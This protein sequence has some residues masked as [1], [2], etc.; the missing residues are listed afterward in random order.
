MNKNIVSRIRS[1]TPARLA[2]AAP[3][4]LLSVAFAPPLSAQTNYTWAGNGT[5]LWGNSNA[6][7][8]N[9]TNLTFNNRTDIIFDNDTV[10]TRGNAT[11]INGARTIR[12][13][14]IGANYVGS[15][16]ATFDIRTYLNF[17]D[18]AANLTFAA[19]SGNASITVAQSTSG[20]VQV[21]LGAASSSTQNQ[22]SIVLSTN[23]DLAQNNTH[24]G[25]TG[26]QFDGKITGAGAIN[27]TG[28][29]E[30][31]LA[32]DNSGWSGG[33]NINEGNVTIFA[34]ANAMGTGTW[35]LGGGAT[36]TS[37][38][39][40][41]SVTYANAGGIVVAAGA[42]TRTIANYTNTNA[43]GNATLSGAI[44]LNK[45]AIFD[46]TQ[47]TAGTHD[48]LSLSGAVGGT[49]GIVKTGTG[50]LILSNAT[51]S[52]GGLQ[53]NAGQVTLQTNATV[54]GLSG[55]GGSL[56]LAGGTLTVNAAASSSYGQVISG[57]GALTKSGG[58]TMTLGG[59]NTYGGATTVSAG[60]LI[61]NGNQS[62]ATGLLT[63]AQNAT[64]G[65]SGTIGGATTISG[66]LQPGNSPG[67]LTFSSG[68]TLTGTAV[69]TM[70][71]NGLARGTDYDV[72]NVVG[73]LLTY[74][75]RLTLSLSGPVYGI[76][77]YSFDLFDFVSQTGSFDV[78]ELL[79][80]YSGSLT[81]NGSGV[82][83]LSSGN[84]TWSFSQADGVLTLDVVP[85]PST[86]ALLV[87]S[88]AG[89]AAHVVR[90]RRRLPR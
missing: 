78:V 67:I 72:I 3:L 57:A 45:D 11:S 6:W 47:V 37:L 73:G 69:T 20:A 34:N 13:L 61:V 7:V 24:F 44:T 2:L 79:G 66:N 28:L 84:D 30:V 39:V 15:T 40:G 18:T 71:I 87:L 4:V 1:I 60:S 51:N 56:A 16:T 46:I 50:L 76:G 14:T 81:N 86:Y 19:A 29:G 88:A 42:G 63:V 25:A 21:R 59:T 65:G 90:R 38:N 70:E 5:Q 54:T 12:S 85:E 32:R 23:L 22:G 26:F 41:S 55:S 62:G 49:G 31:R 82:W 33:M 17:G 27:K 74:D 10:V 36:N 53:I 52:F 43:A 83:G 89:L 75:G 58:G 80:S 48:R 64:L 68:L 77:I 9:P 8:G 35:T